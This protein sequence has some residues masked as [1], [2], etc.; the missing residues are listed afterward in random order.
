MS[1]RSLRPLFLRC[2]AGLVPILVLAAC[3]GVDPDQPAGE[4]V[5]PVVE[6]QLVF[7]DNF[8]GAEL[9]PTKWNIDEGNGCPDLCGWGNNELQ[10]YTPDNITVAGGVL[11]IQGREEL[12]GT[13]TSGRLNTRGKFDFRYGRIEVSARIP[14]G[15][16]TWPAIWL[17]HSPAGG[18]NP[19]YGDL[20]IYGPWPV[21]GE[22][23]I[24]EGFNYGVGGNQETRSTAHYGLPIPPFN[25][26]GSGTDLAVNADLNFHEYALEWERGRLRFFVDGQHFQTQIIDEYYAYY[27]A[28]EDGFYDPFGPYTLGLD[29]APFDQAF[30]LIMNFAIGGN[31]VGEPDA[32][33]PFPQ[34]MEIDYVRIYEC[35][36]SNPETR[37]GCGTADASIEPL[38]DHAGGPLENL[39]TAKPYIELVDL[40]LDGPETITLT[41]GQESGS[42]TLQ[43]N[44]WDEEPSTTVVNEPAF[45]DPDDPA[46]IVWH[47]NIAGNVGNVSLDSQ[48]L[49]DDPLLDTGFDFSGSGLGGDPVGEIVFDM[50]VNSITAGTQLLVKMQSAWPHLGEVAIPTSELAIG[51]WKTYSIKFSDL[52]SNP[53]GL[54]CGGQGLDLE[55][56]R[57]PFVF[58]VVN[59]DADV[60]IDNIRVTNACYVAGACNASLRTKGIPDLVVFDDAVNT[61]TWDLGI[62]GADSGIGWGNDY[63]DGTNPAAKVNWT[64][65]DDAD[66]ARGQVVDITF[67]D[68]GA[69]GVWY[70]ASSTGVNTNAFSA[71]AVQFDLIVDD[72]GTGDG[73]TM[74]IDCFDPC[75]SG[76]R[77][78][79]RVADGEWQTITAFVANL[80]PPL[81][82]GNVNTGLVLFPTTQT[83]TIRFRVDNIRWVADTDALPK[84]QID[85]PVTFEDPATDYSVIDFGDPVAASTNVAAE[86]PT[87]PGNTVAATVKPV[88]APVWAGTVIGTT[89]GFA[90][91][92]PFAAGETSMSVHVYSPAENIPVLLKVENIDDATVFAEVTALTTV[93]NQWE[94]LVFDFSTAGID[95]NTVYQ[96]AIIFFDFGFEGTGDTYYWDNVAFGTGPTLAQVD[97]PVTFE[98]SGVAYDLGDFGGGATTLVPDPNNAS[99]TV[100][101]TNKPPGAELWSGVTIGATNG[102]ANPIPFSALD[103]QM[104]V[105]VYSPDAGIPVRLKVE[106]AANGAISV[107][108][109][110]VTT[111]AGNWEVLTFDFSSQVAGTS[112]LD[113]TQVYDKVSIFFNFGTD[114]TT[115]GDKTY[116]WDNVI[117]LSTPVLQQVDLPITFDSA[118]VDY[119]VV[120]F[121]NAGAIVGVADP[122]NANNLVAQFNKPPGSELW[123]GATMGATNGLANPIPF[124]A[125][126]TRMSVRFYSPD[127][128]IPVRL[129]VENVATAAISVET[130]ATTTV[131][132]GWETLT[133]NF[134]NN[135]GG[136]PA[137][138]LGESYGKVIIFPNFGTDGNTA[139]DKTYF[140]DDVEFGVPLNLP[141]T[142][143]AP[144]VTYTFIDFGG[145]SST[146]GT[147]PVNATNQVGVTV[148]NA[149]SEV[150][151]GTIVGNDAGFANK[152]P[153]AG[154]A[155]TMS[156]SV[157]APVAGIPVRLKVEDSANGTISVET[158]ALT[159]V[160]GGWEVLTFDFINNVA[161][162][163]VLDLA[164]TYDKAVIFFNFGTAGD[165]STYY[166]DDLT[167]G[168]TP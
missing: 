49:T 48:D 168:V 120:A 67:N 64:I 157:Y 3:G 108:T 27:P 1:S 55:S 101:S 32:A 86:D 91:P 166:W 113:P 149:G 107:E 138:N 31:P 39:V 158:E 128:G 93:A 61:A 144:G 118:N 146:V 29:D 66:A 81:D 119:D 15:R 122:E 14:S 137:L 60:Y 12:D 89:A 57:T 92:I 150:W 160:G 56:V 77:R 54:C 116:L 162:T 40:F 151:A 19:K 129:K 95:T 47:V 155:T 133:F 105:A 45:P 88:G 78:L 36:N 71:G 152:I 20:G 69:F 11:S 59:G 153:F 99:N 156:L 5:P 37:R 10:V 167:F 139:G 53:G 100:A 121:G 134:A 115:A 127:A 68:N 18:F 35:A 58:E 102:L 13:Y 106:N 25:G 50:Q 82:L 43:V 165:G 65:I 130:E 110:A 30:H 148:K 23:D 147:D 145:A 114:G 16:G 135:V 33:T 9:D 63:S 22:I 123:A 75:S 96:R 83:G 164:Q 104:T 8:D 42:N 98:S 62:R 79:G 70:I 97:L 141:V 159:A 28:N 136:T 4:F 85:L 38:K 51:E 74:K 84:N 46:N 132:N 90:N 44:A 2:L 117:F 140:W 17:L 124:T 80:A 109:E 41:V 94:T 111:L 21:S 125:T 52:L 6:W 163:P 142:F 34:A 131:A 161:G 143:D 73:M 72:Y 7:E 24:M 112:A 87:D 76:E 103:T 154:G 126:D 26:T